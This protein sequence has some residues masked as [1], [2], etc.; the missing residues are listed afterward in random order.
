M[1]IVKSNN[2]NNIFFSPTT[3]FITDSNWEDKI[4]R[5]EQD[6]LKSI[7]NPT[8]NYETSLF[9]HEYQT[10]GQNDIWFY[11]YFYYDNGTSHTGGLNYEKVDITKEDNNLMTKVFTESFFRLDF[12][13]IPGTPLEY[14]NAKLVMT[15]NLRLP[16]SAK[17]KYSGDTVQFLH[18]PIFMGSSITNKENMNLY[19]FTDDNVLAEPRLSG[20]TF[21]MTAKYMNAVDGTTIPF[22]INSEHLYSVDN[23]ATIYHK[24]VLNKTN[25]TYCVYSGNTLTKIGSTPINPIKFYAK[26]L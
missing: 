16:I 23:P 20:D 9:V 5:Y 6:T 11:F 19:W 22:R 26:G 18:V 2:D 3:N 13:K 1:E 12:Y 15:K 17:V 14:E 10:N 24:V 8:I 7:I 4:L 25:K 21:Y